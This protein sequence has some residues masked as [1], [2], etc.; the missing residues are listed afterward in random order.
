MNEVQMAP[1]DYILWLKG[2]FDTI[3]DRTPT[4]EEWHRFREQNIMQVGDV[5]MR[6]VEEREIA[7]KEQM[8]HAILEKDRMEQYQKLQAMQAAQYRYAQYPPSGQIIM[9]EDPY[10][11]RTSTQLAAGTKTSK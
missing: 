11:N 9:T 8:R 2:M 5:V 10:T 3:G 6:R 1:D 7:Q 4:L